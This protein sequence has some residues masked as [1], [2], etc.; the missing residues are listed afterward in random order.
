MD[1]LRNRSDRSNIWDDFEEGIEMD[2]AGYDEA[3]EMSNLLEVRPL[4]G[5]ADAGFLELPILEF[6]AIGASASIV[7]SVISS[8][9]GVVV[10]VVPLIL[11]LVQSIMKEQELNR[12]IDAI[13]HTEHEFDDTIQSLADR[14]NIKLPPKETVSITYQVFIPGQ[15]SMGDPVMGSSE[16]RDVTIQK[17]LSWLWT[18]GPAVSSY[19]QFRLSKPFVSP[20]ILT[21]IYNIA[22]RWRRDISAGPM[23]ISPQTPF[24][25][26][27]PE[28]VLSVYNAEN[29]TAIRNTHIWSIEQYISNY[30]LVQTFLEKRNGPEFHEFIKQVISTHK[31]MVTKTTERVSMP[32]ADELAVYLTSSPDMTIMY[33]DNI[34]HARTKL[35]IDIDVS[36]HIKSIGAFLNDCAQYFTSIP[37]NDVELFGPNQKTPAAQQVGQ[38]APLEKTTRTDLLQYRPLKVPSDVVDQTMSAFNIMSQYY[39]KAREVVSL[40]ELLSQNRACTAVLYRALTGIAMLIRSPTGSVIHVQAIRNAAAVVVSP[41]VAGVNVVRAARIYSYGTGSM[42]SLA[43]KSIFGAFYH[44]VSSLTRKPPAPGTTIMYAPTVDTI[45]DTLNV[46][47]KDYVFK[48]IDTSYTGDKTMFMVSGMTTMIDTQSNQIRMVQTANNGMLWL[49]KGSIVL[50]G[51]MAS[52]DGTT[53]QAVYTDKEDPPIRTDGWHTPAVNGRIPI[54]RFISDQDKRSQDLIDYYKMAAYIDKRVVKNGLYG[55]FVGPLHEAMALLKTKMEPDQYNKAIK[56]MSVARDF[57]HKSHGLL[58]ET[59][60]P[61]PTYTLVPDPSN[62]PDTHN[63][64][65]DFI[66]DESHIE[67]P[68]HTRIDVSSPSTIDLK[69]IFTFFYETAE[70]LLETMRF[71]AEYNLLYVMFRSAASTV[72]NMDVDIVCISTVTTAIGFT[73]LT[74]VVKPTVVP[75]TAMTT[76]TIGVSHVFRRFDVMPFMRNGVQYMAVKTGE[77]IKLIATH[78][79]TGTMYVAGA[80]LTGVGNTAKYV[81]RKSAETSVYIAGYV[82]ATLTAGIALYTWSEFDSRSNKKRKLNR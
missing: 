1:W 32:F 81:F 50:A 47:I 14:L 62:I 24:Q 31:E 71:E 51:V 5:M 22:T 82:I 16:I 79:Y 58:D 20:D 6:E 2:E 43:S 11:V 37:D 68:Q 59:E 9:A 66:E 18:L 77:N 29:K 36:L 80:I 64:V 76:T 55:P 7:S 12:V 75:S 70:G 74:S 78:A 3:L 60:F 48:D 65:R 49:M 41:V 10:I 30:N 44:I 23:I 38:Y 17:Q 34:E 45:P 40:Q 56:D 63:D 54:S 28:D 61:E 15:S 26:D 25:R 67:W 33:A 19:L 52:A 39:F 46:L 13:A 35:G 27:L 53:V 73:Y 57:I 69:G 72:S 4:F 8:V 21:T 42:L